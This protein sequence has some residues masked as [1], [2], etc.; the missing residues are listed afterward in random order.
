MGIVTWENSDCDVLL[1]YTMS[2]EKA[3]KME[4]SFTLFGQSLLVG[5]RQQDKVLVMST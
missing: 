5:I 4:N 1:V 3:M 2:Q